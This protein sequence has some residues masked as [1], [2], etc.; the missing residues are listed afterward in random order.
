[1]NEQQ[2]LLLENRQTPSL[3]EILDSPP[4]SAINTSPQI[5]NSLDTLFPE[6]QYDENNLKKA[7]EILGTL[8]DEFTD[9]QLKVALTEI[10]FLSES[11][12]DDF[13]RKLFKGVTLQE[14]LH[15]KGG[16]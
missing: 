9:E 5:K 11:W 2:L 7:K 10:I 6:Q 12:L 16:Q 14:L 8:T 3:N 13:E 15:E 4:Q 1:M